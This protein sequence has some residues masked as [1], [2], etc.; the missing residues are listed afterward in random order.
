MGSLKEI[1]CVV[2]IV[3]LLL[4]IAGAIVGYEAVPCTAKGGVMVN[5]YCIK[6]DAIL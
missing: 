3:F 4:I 1:V 6:K 2:L 5:G